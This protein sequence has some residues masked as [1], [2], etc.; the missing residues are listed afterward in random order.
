MVNI[1]DLDAGK[2]VDDTCVAA[3]AVLNPA[4]YKPSLF[5]SS[6]ESKTYGR[7][8]FLAKIVRYSKENI[9]VAAGLPSP[10]HNYQNT[11]VERAGLVNPKKE[12]FIT[13][14]I[15]YLMDKII[16]SQEQVNYFSLGA[17][18]NLATILKINPELANKINLIQMGPSLDSIYR[19]PGS[20]EYNARIDIPSFMY[21]MN[22][23]ENKKFIMSHAASQKYETSN[24]QKLGV[25]TKGPVAIALKES[26]NKIHNL[27]YQHLLAWEEYL[28][29]KGDM[30]KQVCSIMYDPLTTLTHFHNNLVD[31][32]ESELIYNNALL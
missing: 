32:A 7:A 3:M 12:Y 15:D 20:P 14:G 13:N 24:K 28:H 19:K 17:L 9:P 18:T 21:V 2:D 27:F 6:D 11:L 1:Y 4:K 16:D 23:V 22:T 25:Y 30:K 31:F 5:I 29:N 26:K 8:A 10:V